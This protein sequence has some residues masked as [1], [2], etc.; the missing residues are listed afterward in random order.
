MTRIALAITASLWAIGL[1]ACQVQTRDE[2]TQEALDELCAL[3]VISPTTAAALDHI[4]LEVAFAAFDREDMRCH[5][6]AATFIGVNAPS[7]VVIGELD[8]LRER[9]RVTTRGSRTD[10]E[11]AQRTGIIIAAP[12]NR[13]LFDAGDDAA[14]LRAAVGQAADL[15]WWVDVEAATPHQRWKAFV[16]ASEGVLG[17]STIPQP[18]ALQRLEALATRSVSSPDAR[19]DAA[20]RADLGAAIGRWRKVYGARFGLGDSAGRPPRE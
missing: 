18:F 14:A 4:D 6:M 11:I 3:R 13:R 20:V 5:R 1:L 19:L 2:A 8:E 10:L 7:R 12:Y 9:V 17:L 16:L 15:H